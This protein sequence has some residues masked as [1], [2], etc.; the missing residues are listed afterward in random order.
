MYK[1]WLGQ[2]QGTESLCYRA[3]GSAEALVPMAESLGQVWM[4]GVASEVATQILREVMLA[5]AEDTDFWRMVNLDSL[6]I[7]V[8]SMDD[9]EAKL[10]AARKLRQRG[11]K[12]PIITP[13][14]IM[15]S[16]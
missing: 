1:E 8:L 7:V 11:F 16:T 6:R 5:D 10:I 12:G 4:K 13:A 15:M 14:L 3:I 2:V 9:F